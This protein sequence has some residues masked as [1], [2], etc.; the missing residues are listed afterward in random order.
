ML[1]RRP[2]QPVVKHLHRACTMSKRILIMSASVGSGHTRAAAA[3]AKAFRSLPD[4]GDVICDDV[5][6]HTNLLYRELNSSLY[7]VLSEIAPN[8][9]GWWYEKTNDPWKSD[10][11]LRAIERFNTGPLVEYVSD[12]KPDGIVCTHFTPAGVLS[13]LIARGKLDAQLS[14]VVTDFHF[15]AFWLV[16]AFHW[17]FVAH[18]EDKVHMQ[19]LGLPGERIRITGI[20]VD[21][22]FAEPIDKDEVRARFGLRADRPMVLVSAGTLGL[23][24]AAVIVRRLLAL[25]D[26]L[27]MV[28]VCGRNEKLK[29]EVDDLVADRPGTHRVLGY[30]TEMRQ[31]MGVAD[32]LL[33]KPGGLITAEALA[34]GLPMVILDPVGGQEVR[35]AEMLLENGVAIRCAESTLLPFKVGRLLDNPERLQ[36]MAEN[37]RRLGRPQAAHSIARTV[38][39]HDD[40]SPTIITPEHEAR[41]RKLVEAQ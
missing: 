21:P 6:D 23:G 11:V 16:R 7:A 9:L 12:L 20:P 25:G 27:Q 4:V 5:L 41:L 34:C 32:L 30:T 24:P 40:L 37:A 14:V 17:Y 38:M 26:A 33:S 36:R 3:L 28:V 10:K 35:N 19:E 31:L 1:A 18:D 2:L 13:H 39:Q 8:F 15:H 22:A 29:A